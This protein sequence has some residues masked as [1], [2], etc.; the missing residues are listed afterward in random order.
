MIDVKAIKQVAYNKAT[1]T[2][3]PMS[4]IDNFLKQWWSDKYHRPT[5]DPLLL[6]FTTEELMLEYYYD[7]FKDNKDERLKFEK[8]SQIE[9]EDEDEKWFKKVMGEQY[10]AENAYS[11]EMKEKISNAKNGKIEKDDSFDDNFT[12]G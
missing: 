10:N 2:S 4:D 11:A 8:E 5:N 7:I 1:A 6:Q 9:T 3:V 12:L